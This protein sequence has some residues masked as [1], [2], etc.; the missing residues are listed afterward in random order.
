MHIADPLS[1]AY[2]PLAKQESG[3]NEEVWS[4]VDTRSP[5]EIETEYIDLIEFVPI[6]QLTLKL[7]S[8]TARGVIDKLKPHLTRYGL[9]ERITTDNGPQFYCSEFQKF[10]VEYPFEHI[11]TSQRYSQSNGKA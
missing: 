7:Q 9:S 3:D 11:T 4:I 1:R 6:L 2:L 8:K 5:T 10:A